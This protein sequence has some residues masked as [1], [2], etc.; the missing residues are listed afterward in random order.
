[1][2]PGGIAVVLLGVTAGVHVE[3]DT[4]RPVRLA[5]VVTEPQAKVRLADA[6]GPVDHGQRARK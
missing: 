2:Q 6:G 4:G 1:M 3:D 5:A